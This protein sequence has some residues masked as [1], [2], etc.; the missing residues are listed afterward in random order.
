M[1]YSRCSATA[2]HKMYSTKRSSF[3]RG[4]ARGCL[5]DWPRSVF[6]GEQLNTGGAGERDWST[7]VGMVCGGD[8]DIFWIRSQGAEIKPVGRSY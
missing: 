4:S 8:T 3:A 7:H 6:P 1:K 5:L 2:Q